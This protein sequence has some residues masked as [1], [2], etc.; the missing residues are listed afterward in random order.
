MTG[1]PQG[2]FPSGLPT[3]TLYRPLPSP[4][5]ATCPSHLILLG[6]ITHARL[7]KEYRPFSSSLC[8]F[9]Y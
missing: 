4:I 7:G 6:F 9:L 3:K 1:S 2:L 8:K 5:R